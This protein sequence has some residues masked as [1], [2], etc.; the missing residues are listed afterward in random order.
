MRVLF[1][2]GIAVGGQHLAV[3]IGI[4]ALARGLLEQKLQIAQIVA[5]DHDERPFSTVSG[6]ETGTG[7]S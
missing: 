5:G 6:T 3:G 1:Q 2:R 4:D 7:S